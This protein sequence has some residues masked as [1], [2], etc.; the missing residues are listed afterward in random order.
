MIRKKIEITKRKIGSEKEWKLLEKQI[1][2]E[3]E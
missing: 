1:V 2:I 3:E